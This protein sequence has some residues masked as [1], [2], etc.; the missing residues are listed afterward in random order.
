MSRRVLLVAK[1]GFAW[2]AHYLAKLLREE[3]TE[4][5]IFFIMPHEAMRGDYDYREFVRLN[6]DLKI[7]DA[8]KLGTEFRSRVRSGNL[9]LDWE[10]LRRIDRE[11]SAGKTLGLQQI[12]SQF[13]ST[14][15]HYRTYYRD[16]PVE[17]Q[18]LLMQLYYGLVHE[19]LDEF[20]P[21]A[22]YDAD[23]SEY[24]R[25]ILFEVAGRRNIPYVTI[26]GSRFDDYFFPSTTLA[27]ADADW[28]GPLVEQRAREL[29][30]VEVRSSRAGY[31]E[32]DR[33]RAQSEILAD[34]FKIAYATMAF[35]PL[36]SL[37]ALV[38]ANFSRFPTHF[39][40][41]LR[42]Y[43]TGTAPIF[44]DPI[45]L[46]LLELKEYFRKFVMR[47]ASPFVEA[48]LS[49][50]D[51]IL[52]PLHLIPESSTLT[53]SPF[54]LNEEFLV[55]SLSKSVPPG[56]SIVVKEHWYMMGE[57]PLSFYRRMR[58]LPNV[59]LIEPRKY[60]DPRAYLESAHGVVTITGTSAFEAALLRKPS[61]VFG[62]TPFS[63]LTSVKTVTDVTT[64][65]SV[66]RNWSRTMS[67]DAELAAYLEIAMEVGEKLDMPCLTSREHE[68]DVSKAKENAGRLYRLFRRGEEMLRKDRPALEKQVFRT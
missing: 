23:F 59:I 32:L 48:D 55:E 24:P 40:D 5:G 20:R 47:F 50:L 26:E 63:M 28:L 54:F 30:T 14:Y 10:A 2:P 36:R 66:V 35:R 6:P 18:Y 1:E 31:R 37:Y 68:T 49:K 62:P 46:H 27:L 9:G 64:L 17:Q 39:K 67:D 3:G 44:A 56:Q 45:R 65:P 34:G 33:F 42:F 13:M 16:V 22:I 58:R 4:I 8:K 38:R 29:R 7:F 61:I 15:A 53:K 25:A 19:V 43:R 11:Y 51:Y 12:T 52:F 57:R 41:W 60:G 21:D